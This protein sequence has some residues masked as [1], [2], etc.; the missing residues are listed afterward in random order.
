MAKP[1]RISSRER[2]AKR[3]AAMRAQ[4][5]RP[6]QIWLPDTSDPTFRAQLRAEGE[7]ISKAES[8][9]DDMAFVEAVQYWPPADPD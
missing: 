9:E 1:E 2:V 5:L 3:R 4:G 6:R 8:F 7:A